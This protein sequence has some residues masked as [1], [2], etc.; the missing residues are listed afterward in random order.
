MTRNRIRGRQQRLDR[1]SQVIDDDERGFRTRQRFPQPIERPRGLRFE[2]SKIWQELRV[3]VLQRSEVT[4]ADDLGALLQYPRL[5][6]VAERTPRERRAA[7]GRTLCSPV[8]PRKVA[9]LPV[10]E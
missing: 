2:N 7:A 4:E 5:A 6:Q 3:G 10:A 9:P 8:R 1:P